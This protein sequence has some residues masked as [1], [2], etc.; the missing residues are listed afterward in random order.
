MLCA[1]I[2]NELFSWKNKY[3]S[4]WLFTLMI[5]YIHNISLW[6]LVISHFSCVWEESGCVGVTACISALEGKGLHQLALKRRKIDAA[7]CGRQLHAQSACKTC[8]EGQ[9]GSARA[10]GEKSRRVL[11]FCQ[12]CAVT[13]AYYTTG[14]TH[15]WNTH[16]H[17]QSSKRQEPCPLLIQTQ[18][19]DALAVKYLCNWSFNSL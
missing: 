13:A 9:R 4:N 7:R 2:H 3:F 1:W 6:C 17:T 15:I 19:T 14:A 5:M 18:Q 8:S 16:T 12:S 10:A 11:R